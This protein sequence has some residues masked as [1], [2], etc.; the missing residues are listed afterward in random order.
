[1]V[2]T[3]IVASLIHTHTIYTH[4]HTFSIHKKLGK[5]KELRN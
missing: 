4:K 1:M 2:L 3:R 5:I